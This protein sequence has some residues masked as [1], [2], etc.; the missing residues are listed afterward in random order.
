MLAN[1]D[2]VDLHDLEHTWMCPRRD[3][4]RIT[5]INITIIIIWWIVM[6]IIITELYSVCNSVSLLYHDYMMHC[7]IDQ[8]RGRVAF[9]KTVGKTRPIW[10]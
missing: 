2:P 8:D 1:D 7:E 5:D 4:L 3:R 9:V 10:S 6:T